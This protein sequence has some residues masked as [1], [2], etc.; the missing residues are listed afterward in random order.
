MK[1]KIAI[2]SILFGIL[3][4]GIVSASFLTY[5]GRIEGSVEVTGPVFYL[6]NEHIVDDE[7]TQYWALGINDYIER[8]IPVSFTGGNSKWFISPSLGVESFYEA[9]WEIA[10]EAESNNESGKIDIA[11]YIVNGGDPYHKQTP[12][13]C[14]KSIDVFTK[15]TYKISCPISGLTLDE[16]DRIAIILSDGANSI[17][18]KVYLNGNSK[19]EV[20]AI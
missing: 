1:K 15:G 9:N 4:I 18:Y 17:T 8:T 6:S 5:F 3:L 7:D 13:L 11:I 19:I 14:E 16:S 10:L 2:V 20:S 12:A